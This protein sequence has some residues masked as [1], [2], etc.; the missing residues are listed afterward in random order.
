MRVMKKAIQIGYNDLFE[1]KCEYAREAG[2]NHI[3][4]NFYEMLGKT[5]LEWEKAVEHIQGIL[6]KLH[7][8]CVQTHPYYYDLRD[9]S[10]IIVDECEFAIKQAVKATGELGAKWCALHPRSS[11][12]SGFSV[13]KSFEDNKRDFSVYLE[14]A[15]KYNTGLAAENLP[16]FPG[17]S[18]SMPFYSSDY[19]DLCE[20]VDSFN[21]SSMAICWDTGHANLMHFDQAEAIKFLGN[22]IKCTHIHNNDRRN[23][24]HF[25]P[26]NGSIEWDKV[27]AAF[28]SV[29]YDGPLTLE[30]HCMYPADDLLKNFARHNLGCLE[31][32]ERL[33][34][35]TNK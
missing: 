1:K 12:S 18:P 32:L 29:G 28:S 33:Y 6:S 2:F 20:L 22:R 16:I 23:D 14:L 34:E 7:I 11:I 19:Y 30:T 31:Y 13:K 35:V 8:E 5:E 15:K 10:E 3:A 4:V 24:N 21:D 26:D 27:M 9:S 25:P 17:L